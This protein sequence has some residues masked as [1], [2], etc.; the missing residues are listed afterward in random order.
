MK[1]TTK[2]ISILILFI[3]TQSCSKESPCNNYTS[4]TFSYK[5]SENTKNQIPFKGTDTLTYI[6]NNGDTAILIGQGKNNY[7]LN[8]KI[9]VSN[10]PACPAEFDNYSN[11]FVDI[12]YKGT[13]PNL[14]E[15]FIR[16]YNE[17]PFG[18]EN[19]TV[20]LNAKSEYNAYSG[21]FNNVS[22]YI[23]LIEINNAKIYAIKI[24][25]SEN[26]PIYYNKNYGIIQIALDSNTIF[27]LNQ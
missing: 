14:F 13:N 16:Y 24:F 15:I 26:N 22:Y 4:Q 8:S 19:T 7:I 5:L 6:S 3:L 20:Y 1:T 25:G 18:D 10:N 21:Y 27:T 11:E 12:K 2:L 23:N 17:N 9:R